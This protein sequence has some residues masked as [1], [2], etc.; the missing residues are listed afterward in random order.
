MYISVLD[1]TGS[2]WFLET[3]KGPVGF[4]NQEVPL[5]GGAQ[6]CPL[7][8]RPSSKATS[9]CGASST[10]ASC[11]DPNP[12]GHVLAPTGKVLLR[13]LP[14]GK[15]QVKFVNCYS[16]TLQKR[17]PEECSWPAVLIRETELIA[18]AAGLRLK[19]FLAGWT[20]H[21]HHCPGCC[22]PLG[23]ERVSPQ[24]R[25]HPTHPAGSLWPKSRDK[26]QKLKKHHRF[27]SAVFGNSKASTECAALSR[28][29]WRPFCLKDSN[30][31][32]WQT[33]TI[34][35]TRQNQ[36]KIPL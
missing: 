18:G 25:P 24:G 36:K 15:L 13:F 7:R 4:G 16:R 30:T 6:T 26:G 2:H 34:P 19:L 9:T 27:F 11:G 17:V 35:L 12:S 8:A 22:A 21:S 33:C 3:A 31:E 20:T 32:V 28:G 29:I 14:A 23:K 1:G 5:L 10:L